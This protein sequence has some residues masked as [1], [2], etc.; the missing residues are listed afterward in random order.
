MSKYNIIHIIFKCCVS[1]MYLIG[2][3]QNLKLTYDLI[4]LIEEKKAL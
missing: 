1:Y 2:M 3:L 4:D